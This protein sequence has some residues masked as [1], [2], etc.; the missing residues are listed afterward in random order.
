MFSNMISEV[1]AYGQGILIA[2]QV[3]GRLNPDAIKNT[4]LKIVH[5]LVSGDDRVMM[6]VCLDLEAPHGRILGSLRP[7]H[8]L[9]RS[10]M[11]NEAAWIHVHR[12]K[13]DEQSQRGKAT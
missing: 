11:D 2:D 10:D 7:G 1:R 5:R 12:S 4:N 9:I 6:A 8:A 3:P 13:W